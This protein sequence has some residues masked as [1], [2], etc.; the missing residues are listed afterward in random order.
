MPKPKY[1]PRDP[2]AAAL[3]ETLRRCVL[4]LVA[5]LQNK[6]RANLRIEAMR[7]EGAEQVAQADAIRRAAQRGGWL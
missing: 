5:E 2:A 6:G 4:S 7:V 3:R 1:D